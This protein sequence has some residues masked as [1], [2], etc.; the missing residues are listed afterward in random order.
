MTRASPITGKSLA[1]DGP[2][3]RRPADEGIEPNGLPAVA[4]LFCASSA[5]SCSVN[6][7]IGVQPL[8]VPMFLVDYYGGVAQVRQNTGTFVPI[9]GPGGT[10][11]QPSLPTFDR[12]TVNAKAR[13]AVMAIIAS[14]PGG[15][16]VKRRTNWAADLLGLPF[17]RVRHYYK[18]RVRRVDAHEYLQIIARA[19]RAALD[20]AQRHKEHYEKLCEKA[21]D[22]MESLVAL[23]VELL[24]G[25]DAGVAAE[26][27]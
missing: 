1:V 10:T 3:L 11:L 8:V 14:A 27:L 6:R 23:E 18:N 17:Q 13:G 21:P 7:P 19:Q 12:H 2:I 9:L 4:N 26:D 24:G 15:G 5:T 16:S 20:A 22:E 25:V